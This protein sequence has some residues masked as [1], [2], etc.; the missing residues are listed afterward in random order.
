MSL[1]HSSSDVHDNQHPGQVMFICYIRS[2]AG[3]GL[4]V[5]YD[6]IRLFLPES[7]PAEAL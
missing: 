6:G 2:L 5:L 7:D 4:F 1:V 3:E